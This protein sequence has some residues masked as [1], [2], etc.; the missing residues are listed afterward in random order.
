MVSSMLG[1][2]AWGLQYA[3]R[4]ALLQGCIA[5]CWTPCWLARGSWFRFCCDF[6]TSDVCHLD[7]LSS[8]TK[9]GL[10]CWSLVLRLRIFNVILVP[11]LCLQVILHPAVLIAFLWLSLCTTWRWVT[12]GKHGCNNCSWNI[13]DVYAKMA[14]CMIVHIQFIQY[15]TCVQFIYFPG[16]GK[17]ESSNPRAR[18]SGCHGSCCLQC[19]LPAW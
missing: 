12:T 18:G 3:L 6:S 17:L 14:C 13:C 9:I 5:P 15:Y 16:P 19:Q 1:D 7:G 2:V 8:V 4:I 10:I 11:F